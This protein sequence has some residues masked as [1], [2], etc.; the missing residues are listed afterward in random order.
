M[1]SL[2]KISNNSLLVLKKQHTRVFLKWQLYSME[3]RLNKNSGEN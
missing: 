2:F 3:R 1:S